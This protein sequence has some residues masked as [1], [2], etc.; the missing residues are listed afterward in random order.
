MILL[1]AGV[2]LYYASGI[3]QWLNRERTTVATYYILVTT[4]G[5]ILLLTGFGNLAR[6]IRNN[7][8]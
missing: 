7:L 3:I 6:I 8:L 2:V 5:Y 1:T 4:T